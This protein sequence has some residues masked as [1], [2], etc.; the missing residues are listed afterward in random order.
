M[1][2]NS[3]AP[4]IGSRWRDKSLPDRYVGTIEPVLPEYV[5]PGTRL[6]DRVAIRFDG[7]KTL[8]IF[9]RDHFLDWM[10]EAHG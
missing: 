1:S 7:Y 9:A 6:C 2:D 10:E 8:A 5:N 3:P 4:V